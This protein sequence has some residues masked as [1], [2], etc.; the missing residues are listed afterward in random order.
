MGISFYSF[1]NFS[2]YASIAE[3]VRQTMN[4]IYFK[5]KK[6]IEKFEEI[7]EKKREESMSLRKFMNLTRSQSWKNWKI[8]IFFSI[9]FFSIIL[10]FVW[11]LIKQ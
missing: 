6:V 1:L 5:D 10:P 2:K 11:I 8:K 7:I 3:A 4:K 9:W